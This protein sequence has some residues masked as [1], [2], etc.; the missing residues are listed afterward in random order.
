MR[1]LLCTTRFIPQQQKYSPLKPSRNDP[2]AQIGVRPKNC[3][4]RTSKTKKSKFKFNFAESSACFSFMYHVCMYHAREIVSSWYTCTQPRFILS[5][6][7]GMTSENP[8]KWPPNKQILQ[9]WANLIYHKFICVASSQ[10]ACLVTLVN[11]L[12][13]FLKTHPPSLLCTNIFLL[14]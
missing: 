4:K 12:A 2:R 5:A 13:Q 6:P 1:C 7:L 14:I 9:T 10:Q 8:Q 11:S 3:W